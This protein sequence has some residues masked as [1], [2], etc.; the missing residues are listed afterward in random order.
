MKRPPR[1]DNP[2][3]FTRRQVLAAVG[4][5]GAGAV[6][7]GCNPSSSPSSSSS[8]TLRVDFGKTVFA[9]LLKSKIG[10]GRALNSSEILDSLQ[11]LDEI[12]PALY[13]GELRF[14]ETDWPSMQPYP[15]EVGEDGAV[16]VR[17]NTFLDKLDTELRRRDIEVM[18]QLMG[19]PKQW[20]NEERAKPPSKFPRPT[21]LKAAAEAI[22]KWAKLYSDRPVSWCMWN[23]P[24]HNLTGQPDLTSIQQMV[25][26]YEAYT[27]EIGAHGLFG[28]ASFVPV[29]ARPRRHLDGQSYVQTVID[30]LRKRRKSQP[31][32]PFD[33]LTLNNYGE[34]LSELVDGARD[35]LADDFNTVPL[36]Q[37]QFGVFKPGEWHKKSGTTLEAARFMAAL[38]TALA[39]PD[40]Q[41]FTFSG[42][43]PHM[44]AYKGDKAL[45][46]P[47]FHALKLYARMP[48]RRTS[49]RGGLPDGVGT[50]ASGDD[51]R[52]SVLVWNEGDK[53]RTITLDLSDIPAPD[54]GRAELKVYHIDREHGSPLE[55]SG[56]D[57]SPS[58]TAGL[59]ADSH[60]LSKTV[61]VA[62]PG[63]VYVE[64]DAA[65]RHPV[66]DR[67]GLSATLVRRHTYADRVKDSNG[68]TSVRGN[69]YG[70][71]DAVRAIAYL[72]VEGEEGTALCGA[73]YRD[74]PQELEI[75]IAA[76]LPAHTSASA[77]ALFGIRVDY[78]L[79]HGIA[80][81]VLWH[82]NIFDKRRTRPLP[83]GRRGA[84]ADE[85]V[86]APALDRTP[87]DRDTVTLTL[88]SHAPSDWADSGRRA[89]ISFWMD[90]TGPGSQARFLLG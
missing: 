10:V 43:V 4:G 66:L 40:L 86:H 30:E 87:A 82:G 21:D 39:V 32:L 14:P 33:Y 19:A 72:G 31:D 77:E 18:Y 5:I 90:S 64:I 88:A 53:P 75:D 7:G 84:T 17:R 34:D 38:E 24:S 9:P 37:A 61:T 49:V 62:G 6:L 48:D 60:S 73:E 16:E 44:I 8:G 56:N 68:K 35:A 52:S 25:D 3:P 55:D 15:I 81:S 78:A 59:D 26:I 47:L 28:M 76:D 22:G 27:D 41:T 45:Q 36:V 65:S 69:A 85:L 80:K 23:E 20:E 13:D 1:P 89:I 57:F 71:Y 83:W 50:M 46:L 54:R 58:E 12:R 2:T 63:L 79:D 74:L 67:N 70:C 11:Y 51:H 42:W 29:D